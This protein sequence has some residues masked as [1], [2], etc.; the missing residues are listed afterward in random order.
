MRAKRTRPKIELTPHIQIPSSKLF[1]SK[2]NAFVKGKIRFDLRSAMT[3][4]SGAADLF[5]SLFPFDQAGHRRG[6]GLSAG[7][8]SWT[9]AIFVPAAGK[10]QIQPAGACS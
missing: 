2:Q 5:G 9:R 8:G 7:C 4:D 6:H 1:E 10:G 3:V